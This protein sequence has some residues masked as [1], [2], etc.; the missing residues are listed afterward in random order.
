VWKFFRSLSAEEQ[1]D[2]VSTKESFSI[3]KCTEQLHIAEREL[4][5][6]IRAV[7]AMYGQEQAQRAAADW[8]DESESLDSPPR[9]SSRDWRAVTVA[10]S[11]RLANRIT[12]AR[13]HLTPLVA[14]TDT[15]VSPIPSSNCFSSSLLV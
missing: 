2:A 8:L 9:S 5:A 12:V 13:Q 15:K 10:A 4:S 14:A 7:T 3:S 1:E 11:A 6:F